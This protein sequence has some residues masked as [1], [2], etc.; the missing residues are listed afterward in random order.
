M[1]KKRLL[2]VHNIAWSHYKALLFTKIYEISQKHDVHMEVIQVASTSGN[3]K[4]I[5]DVDYSIHKYPRNVLFN[6]N[7]EE[8]PLLR[9]ITS[10][11]AQ[12]KAFKPD[13]IVLPGYDDMAWWSV[14][15]YGKLH[16]VKVGTVIETNEFDKKRYFFK[17]VLKKIFLG[18][19]DYV[20]PCGTKAKEYV[21]KLG[22]PETRISVVPLTTDVEKLI[23]LSQDAKSSRSM[24]VDKYGISKTRNFIYVGR[25]SPEKNLK[26]LIQAFNELKKK[27]PKAEKWGLIVVGDGPQKEELKTLASDL[28]VDG[29]V[30][31]GSTSWD[32]VPKIMAVCDVFVLPSISEPWGLVVNEAMACGLPVVVSKRAGAYW[33]LVRDG[34][35]GFGFDPERKDELVR[36]LDRLVNMEKDLEKLGAV[37]R[38][39]ISNYTIEKAAERFLRAL[40]L[41]S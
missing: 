31:T 40:N 3:R 10:L 23:E 5:G 21:R 13:I 33:D 38:Q 39:I 41:I 20:L 11:V 8:I 12:V 14:A 32:E 36:I 9:K 1:G 35:N 30:F 18:M 29:I 25:L 34:E 2:I 37:S 15:F 24:I 4:G 19:C 16:K 28:K 22:V 6:T 26:L 7:F 17:E 27:N